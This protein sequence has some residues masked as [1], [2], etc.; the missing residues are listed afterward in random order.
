MSSADRSRPRA[1]GLGGTAAAVLAAAVVAAGCGGP[2][3]PPSP[4]S[5]AVAS[6]APPGSTG[7]ASPT[8]APGSP[9]PTPAPSASVAATLG[10][11]VVLWGRPG[12]M[13]IAV[14][15]PGHRTDRVAGPGPALA[16]VSTGGS[17]RL[18]ATTTDGRAFVGRIGVVGG[19]AWTPVPLP[20]VRAADGRALAGSPSFGTLDADGRRAAFVAADFASGGPFDL[21]VV[22]LATGAARSIAL[23]FAADGS[24]P[25][26]LGD[27][28][29]VVTR[30]RG[31]EPGVTAVDPVTGSQVAIGGADPVLAFGTAADGRTVVVASRRD[32]RVKVIPAEDWAA[33]QDAGAAV[34]LEA[35]PDGSRTL[36]WLALSTTGDRLAIVRTDANG[37]AAW[38]DLVG[39]AASWAPAGRLELPLGA[40]RAVVGWLP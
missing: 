21:V 22:D 18:L 35:G 26:W 38:I 7:A 25:A 9:R 6:A 39:R 37:D 20:R 33:G 16:W 32:G 15:G 29:L 14:V 40:D 27:R 28:L 8:S 12:A 1:V 19:P 4:R 13:T 3:I 23:P 2:S 17:D 36:A 34:A 24:P 11:L 30:G 10:R 5:V 31:D